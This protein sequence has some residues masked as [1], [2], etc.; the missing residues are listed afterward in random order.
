MVVQPEAKVLV[1]E[2]EKKMSQGLKFNLEA[3]GYKVLTAYDG[4]EGC[5]KAL[6]EKPDLV[7]LDL[8]LPKCDGYEVCRRLKKEI[9]KLPIIM[10]TARSQEAEVVLGLELGAVD[11]ITKPFSIL[12]LMARIQGVLRRTKLEPTES[13]TFRIGNI[14]ID[15]NKYS[16]N[17][18]GE[19]VEFSPREYEILKY[20]SKHRGEVVKRN[21]L[22]NAVW[23]YDCFSVTRTVDTHIAKLRQK[24]E[25]DPHAPRHIITIHGIG[26]KF[27]D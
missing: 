11:Y 16:A 15:F 18:D 12:E 3:R 1:V 6:E 20:F 13:E 2:D 24:I 7:I 5:K 26:Y 14:Y 21:D 9:P 25:P 8:M 19:P 22:L 10:L 17:R 23:G 4:E 27:L